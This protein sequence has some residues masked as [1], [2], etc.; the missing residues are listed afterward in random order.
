MPTRGG[1]G[2]TSRWLVCFHLETHEGAQGTFQMVVDGERHPNAVVRKGTTR[3]RA[4]HRS[5]TLSHKGAKIYLEHVLRLRDELG[6]PVLVNYSVQW[7]K[8]APGVLF[9]DVPEQPRTGI[10]TWGPREND[11][12]P[13]IATFKPRSSTSSA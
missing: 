11:P 9:C 12:F 13:L 1:K 7:R 4:L 3:L 8:D 5:T 10:E 6:T 2:R